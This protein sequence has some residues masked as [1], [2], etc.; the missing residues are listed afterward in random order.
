[1]V[2]PI[3]A[4][5]IGSQVLGGVMGA[6]G[7]NQAARS[8]KQ[9][10]EYNAQVAE[11]EGILLQ[12]EKTAEEANLRRQSE[13][14]I[15]TQ[16]VAVA[17]SGIQMSGSALQALADT[18]FNREKDAARIQYASSIQQVQKQ[19]EAALVRAQGAAT[20]YGYKVQAVQSLLGGFTAGASTGLQTGAFSGGG[21]GGGSVPKTEFSTNYN[22]TQLGLQ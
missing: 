3:T 15:G 20:A 17:K 5:A 19:S 11:N 9:L 8:A 13:R 2:E 21:G 22:S 7:A 4:I 14:L 10:A 12:R 1:M 6:K 18:Y 16:R